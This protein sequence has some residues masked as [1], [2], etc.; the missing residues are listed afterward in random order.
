MVLL[1]LNLIEIIHQNATNCINHVKKLLGNMSRA[2]PHTSLYL[3]SLYLFRYE[4][5]H[6]L[7]RIL[8]KFKV[9][10]INCSKFSK[11]SPGANLS[12]NIASVFFI[13]IFYK[14][15]I[16]FRAFL[17]TQSDQN[18]HQN[19]SKCTNF[20]KFSLGSYMSLNPLV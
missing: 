1:R 6:F 8:L 15:M 4:S 5:N 11:I 18:I 17:K 13:Y 19:E 14:N 12:T 10:R 9:K 20:S 2:E 3:I 16:I 7:F